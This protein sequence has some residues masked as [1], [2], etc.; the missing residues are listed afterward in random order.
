MQ[1]GSARNSS[2]SRTPIDR[3]ASDTLRAMRISLVIDSPPSAP[4]HR[5][6][7]AALSDAA[8]AR[9]PNAEIRVV[10]TPEIDDAFL[11]SPGD[12]IVIGPGSPYD[13]PDLAEAAIRTARERGVPLVGT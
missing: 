10:R 8:A 1:R 13:R 2:G 11:T 7:L 6:T 9:A 5:A 3:L 12:G 4:Y